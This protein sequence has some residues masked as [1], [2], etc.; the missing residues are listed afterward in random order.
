M[1]L[2]K[3]IVFFFLTLPFL[4]LA[5]DEDEPTFYTLIKPKHSY[6]IDLALPVPVSNKVFKGIMQG[7][8]R[9]SGSYQYSLKNGFYGGLGANYTYFSINRFKISPQI[10]GGM[11]ISNLYLKVGYEKFYSERIGIDGGIK[12]G[13]SRVLIHSDSLVKMNTFNVPIIEPYFAFNLTANDKAAYK[14]MVSYSFLGL[15]FT[16]D[17]IGDFNNGDFAE[18]EFKRITQFFSFGFS[19]SRYLKQWIR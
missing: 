17:K 19:Y 11:N 10:L 1:E 6:S 4:M 7:F 13:V 5:Q 18:S 15:K 14:W 2:S 12:F 8:I 9:F 3:V 16:P